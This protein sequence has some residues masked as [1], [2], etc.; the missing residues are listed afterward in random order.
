MNSNRLLKFKSW[1]T[2]YEALSHDSVVDQV[3]NLLGDSLGDIDAVPDFQFLLRPNEPEQEQV[4]FGLDDASFAL[5]FAGGKLYSVDLWKG[6]DTSPYGTIYVDDG[7]GIADIIDTIKSEFSGVS[8]KLVIK[9]KKEPEILPVETPAPTKTAPDDDYVYGNPDTLFSDMKDY[10]NM[11]IE[12]I[13]PGLLLTGTTGTGK[14]K[15]VKDCLSEAGMKK[16]VD[17][18]FVKGKSTAAGVYL[19]LY[20]NN[21]Q[22]IVFDDCDSVFKDPDGVS[23]LMAALESEDVREISWNTA[24]SAK[25]K[26]STGDAAPK[27]FVFTGYVIFISNI[28]MKHIGAEALQGRIFNLEVAITPQD[29]VKLLEKKLK[30]VMPE[31]PF[32][33]KKLALSIIKTEADKSSNVQVNFRTLIKATKI[34]MHVHDLVKAK[35][36][37]VQQ[38]SY[39]K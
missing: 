33:F 27:K 37:I 9:K 21:G 34:L 28:P 12:H 39:I 31:A 10:V 29:M 13:Q 1:E 26:T 23:V 2:L 32:A 5:N 14:T 19:S 24:G 25:L 16:D 36:M 35:R 17:Y 3:K 18:V 22:L 20:E 11:V 30:T 38:C 4:L 8:E 6:D 15:T 7:H